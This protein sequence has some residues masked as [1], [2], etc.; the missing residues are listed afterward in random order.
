MQF[1]INFPLS[2]WPQTIEHSDAI[3]LNGSCFTENMAGKL[4]NTGF[5]VH[6]NP[7]GI[8]FNPASIMASI[9]DV[10]R[11]TVYTEKDL[12]YLNESYHSWLHHS[13]FS[14]VEASIAV[15]KINA[16]I[17]AAHAFYKKSKVAIITL[18]SAFAYR[19]NELDMLVSNNHKAPSTWFTKELISIEQIKYFLQETIKYLLELNS[20]MRIVFTI[21]P[22]RHLRDG[23]I[24]NNRSKARL[25]EAVHDTVIKNECCTYFPSYEI[26]IDE[27]RD[28][29][30]YDIDFA[31][32][33]YMA[34]SYVWERFKAVAI[35]KNCYDLM[36]SIQQIYISAAHKSSNTQSQ[37]HR[38]FLARHAAL[39][40]KIMQENPYIN[41]QKELAYFEEKE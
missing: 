16:S 6:T 26:V 38:D 17:T 15:E 13:R 27:L 10:A 39:C 25:L 7:H 37:Q 40:K 11:Q 12:F 33:N 31:H 9:R 2:T 41:L 18:G 14:D 24:D 3:A 30:F 21:S 4:Q 28:Y 34:T 1:Q 5:T 32:P 23:V 19:H 35:S 8:L 29:R 36:D 22:V 20:A